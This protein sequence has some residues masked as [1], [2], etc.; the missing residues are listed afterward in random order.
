MVWNSQD[1]ARSSPIDALI[2][3]TSPGSYPLLR[4]LAS[5]YARLG[6]SAALLYMGSADRR[7]ASILDDARALGIEAAAFEQFVSNERKHPPL[8]RLALNPA[9]LRALIRVLNLRQAQA[10]QD[11]FAVQL[12]AAA[13]VLD[14]F[15]PRS[16][17][18]S[19]NGISGPLP[20][21]S[22]AQERGVTCVTVP[23][24]NCR[25]VDL[26]IDQESKR[27]AGTQIVPR[28]LL[29]ILLQVLLSKWINKGPHRGAVMFQPQYIV[30]LEAMGLTLDKP[31]ICHGGPMELMCVENRTGYDQYVGEG[32][33]RDKLALTGSPYCDEMLD[34]IQ[35]DLDARSAL[36]RPR[37]ITP[38]RPRI[39]VSWPPDYHSMHVGKSEFDTYAEMTACYMHFLKSLETCD[40]T[41][42]LHPDAGEIGQDALHQN[43]INVT[44]EHLIALFPK[45]DIFV[46]FFSSAIRWAIA[47][48]K[49]IINIDLY[50]QN[51]KN[52]VHLA[53][54]VHTRSFVEFSEA[55]RT[56]VSS[57]EAF[58]KLAAYQ[59]AA[60]PDYGIMDHQCVARIITEI[61]AVAS[62]TK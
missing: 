42:S 6:R 35:T 18:V 22:M 59:I 7:F 5:R 31:W 38:G 32:L 54:V 26:E 57:P 40:V 30:A 53:G 27:L 16:V 51:I 15:K 3:V 19:E 29:K 60:A 21:L 36:H 56:V 1:D 48:G 25:V 24:G 49:P 61:D 37:Y 23:Y 41:V 45:H 11:M 17:I 52:F 12:A 8:K 33:P 4:Y 10:H 43:G 58:A 2:V 14:R 39:L 13:H 9:I 44:S 34:A 28:G 46:T 20:F 47:A 50:Q 62:R 55:V